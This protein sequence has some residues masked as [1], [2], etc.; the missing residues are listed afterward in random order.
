MTN[1]QRDARGSVRRTAGCIL[2]TRGADGRN[3]LVGASG[4][5]ERAMVERCLAAAVEQG[6]SEHPED[7]MAWFVDRV[8]DAR[9]LRDIEALVV[10]GKGGS[11]HPAV[12]GTAFDAAHPRLAT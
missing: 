7:W 2:L 1:E 4:T 6:G 10:G 3:L 8:P 12:V 5:Q 9:L 11:S